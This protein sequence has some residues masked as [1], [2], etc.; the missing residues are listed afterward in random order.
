M[1]RLEATKCPTCGRIQ[2][3]GQHKKVLSKKLC[4]IMGW[5]GD[6]WKIRNSALTQGHMED[7]IDHLTD[8]GIIGDGK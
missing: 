1:D 8:K 3:R 2:K 6:E 7:L 4:Q 5:K